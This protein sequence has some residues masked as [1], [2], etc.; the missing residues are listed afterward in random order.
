MKTNEFFDAMGK[1]DP[2]LIERADRKAVKRRSFIKIAAIAASFAI[3]AVGLVA[4]LPM[5]FGGEP[6]I[7]QDVIVWEN[8][9]E[10]F[11]PGNS[12]GLTVGESR[13]EEEIIIAKT[14]FAEI[15]SEAFSDYKIGS[16]IPIGN[17][18][19]V[20]GEKLGEVEIRSGW[21]LRAEDTEKDVTTVRA[22]V[23]EIG[24]VAREA[25]V[26]IR[27]L[28]K[29]AANSEYYSYY[30]YVAVNENYEL[31]TLS[32]LFANL[33]ADTYLKMSKYAL[34]LEVP[35]DPGEKLSMDKYQFKDGEGETIRELILSL[36]G[37]GEMVGYYDE[38][39]V[40]LKKGTKMLELTFMLKT[41]NQGILH[42]YVFEDGK[43][44][45]RGVGDGVAIF[46]IGVDATDALF[47]AFEESAVR[48]AGEYGEDGLV[49]ATTG[50][51]N[52]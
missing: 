33:N 8:I 6:P 37:D 23:Y 51:V 13:A 50:A 4:A 3:L 38:A 40:K 12:D 28:E 11:A 20:I 17:N 9:F 15:V 39:G 34:L 36:D 44:A 49:E 5:L 1:I 52:E 32:E 42:I 7:V 24:G 26:A 27:Y 30:Y 2:A 41:S 31:T 18:G 19:T 35:D 43:I 45:I 29:C 16:V 25:A 48:D 22:E 46:N 47:A 10:M 21:Y 14:A